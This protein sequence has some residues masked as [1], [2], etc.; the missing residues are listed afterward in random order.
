MSASIYQPGDDTPLVNAANTLVPQNFTVTAFPTTVFN[1][2]NFTYITGTG[3]LHIYINGVKQRTGIDFIESSNSSFTLTESP[4]LG[5]VVTAEGFV[6]ISVDIPDAEYLRLQLAASTGAGMIGTLAIG[7]LTASTVQ[8][9]LQELVNRFNTTLTVNAVQVQTGVAFTTTG[10]STAYAADISAT[11]VTDGT[12]N[13]R[14]QLTFDET[15]S[16]TTPT[17]TLS[18]WTT[19]PIRVFNSAGAKV[20]P[21]VGAIVGAAIYD[22]VFDGAYWMI[23]NPLPSAGGTSSDGDTVNDKL[24]W[25]YQAKSF[26][27]Y[28]RGINLFADGYKAA[29]GINA[30]A[31]SNYTLDTAIGR[32]LPALGGG[33]VQT[34]GTVTGSASFT[35]GFTMF[36]RG[37]ALTAGD[38]IY[39]LGINK[40][41]AGNVSMK[42]GLQ[43]STTNFTV[44]VNQVFSHPGGGFADVVLTAPYTV[45]VSGTY[46]VGCYI[47][48]TSMPAA[49]SPRSYVG[50]DVTTSS[51]GFTADAST[52]G[53][54]AMR[55]TKNSIPQ[56]MTVVSTAQ[57]V[58]SSTKAKVTIEYDNVATPTL[59]TDLTAEVSCNNGSNWQTASLVSQGLSQAGRLVAES[60][61]ITCVAGTQVAV[62]LKTANNKNVP[63]YGVAVSN[64]N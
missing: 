60:T 51:A 17:L 33:T 61:D 39:S 41:V 43:N 52:N 36:D 50:G 14:L 57:T 30:G 53:I 62:R 56:A 8:D 27:G 12:V 24:L 34:I 9:N 23:L 11:P 54:P 31:S 3:S 55:L 64:S 15:N 46:N 45:P 59:N 42:L 2:T 6:G 29:D 49:S 47:T 32:V 38:V 18:G 35:G 20:G 48:D 4:L 26:A 1:L 16:S 63:V 58:S 25:I 5:D 21:A 19:Y 10:S 40:T 28:R 7:F 22:V 44:V 37:V 13:T